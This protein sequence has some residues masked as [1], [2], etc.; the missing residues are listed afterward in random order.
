MGIQRK[1]PHFVIDARNMGIDT[2][3]MTDAGEHSSYLFR[4][5]HMKLLAEAYG[6]YLRVQEELNELF[7]SDELG[8][9]FHGL[10][11]IET[12]MLILSPQFTDGS[13]CSRKKLQKMFTG[14][15]MSIDELVQRLM[16]LPIEKET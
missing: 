12:L 14:R 5:V 13:D 3:M 16:Q 15:S 11:S 2:V 1:V 7:D 6:S 10:R 8:G 4:P 9:D